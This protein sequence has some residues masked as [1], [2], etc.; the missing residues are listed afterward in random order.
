MPYH[1]LEQSEKHVPRRLSW[2]RHEVSPQHMGMRGILFIHLVFFF[3]HQINP[4]A[5]SPTFSHVSG[6]G[7]GVTLTPL[8]FGLWD[9][10]EANP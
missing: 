4:P 6:L 8:S 10:V 9:R 1:S 3:L 2:N 5:P 7:T